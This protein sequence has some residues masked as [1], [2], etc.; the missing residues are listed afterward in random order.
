MWYLYLSEPPA[1]LL[2]GLVTFPVRGSGIWML[3][4]KTAH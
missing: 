1:S 3:K 2:D 4:I